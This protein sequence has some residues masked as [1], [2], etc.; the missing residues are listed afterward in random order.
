MLATLVVSY[1]ELTL[2]ARYLFIRFIFFG[3]GFTEKWFEVWKY[4]VLKQAK[5][6][7]QALLTGIPCWP[8]MPLNHLFIYMV[9]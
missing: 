7:C 9:S 8:A 6:L 4:N 1:F 2:V 3:G 5:H